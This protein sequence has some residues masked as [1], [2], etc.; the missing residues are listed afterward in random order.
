MTF[1]SLEKNLTESD[2]KKGEYLVWSVVEVKDEENIIIA[3]PHCCLVTF[4]AEFYM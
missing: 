4:L 1:S 2:K 3:V